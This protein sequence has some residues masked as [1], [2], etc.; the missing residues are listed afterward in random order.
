MPF[1]LQGV[2]M[3]PNQGLIN[4][5]SVANKLHPNSK[6]EVGVDDT[7]E[8]G[9]HLRCR[10][11]MMEEVLFAALVA[12]R[13]YFNNTKYIESAHPTV[14]LW[15]S[16]MRSLPNLKHVGKDDLE[17]GLAKRLCNAINKRLED[18]V[19]AYF[20]KEHT[21]NL[22]NIK[23]VIN[24]NISSTRK[25]LKGLFVKYDCLRFIRIDVW[26]NGVGTETTI[27]DVIR[28]RGIYIN[29]APLDVDSIIGYMW[30]MDLT[31]DGRYR[32]Q[33][34]FV[35]GEHEELSDVEL[36][37]KLCSAWQRVVISGGG[38]AN[39]ADCPKEL[40][41]SWVLGDYRRVR[42]DEI[43]KQTALITMILKDAGSDESLLAILPLRPHIFGR[44]KRP[45][46]KRMLQDKIRLT[47]AKK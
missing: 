17:Y 30:R 18:F 20:S 36:G 12:T 24:R 7:R 37:E 41:N 1:M 4:V 38:C 16:T 15:L 26:H 35:I 39:L 6:V 2:N 5:L 28:D 23:S 21:K 46:L 11:F 13:D 10:T 47:L 8:R 42:H 40:D 33:F 44:G 32:H 19:K 3:I 29:V 25:Y 9:Y 14:V 45:S 22:N 43:A 34:V 31:R 27:E